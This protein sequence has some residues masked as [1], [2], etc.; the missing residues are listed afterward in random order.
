[1]IIAVAVVLQLVA[2]QTLD[3]RDVYINPTHIVSVSEARDENDPRK[4]L[5]AKARCV[6][7]LT[8]GKFITVV[9]DCASVRDRL[10]K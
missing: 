1:M 7:T 10:D 8:N 6:I 2:F 3:G 5:T 9:E 4:A